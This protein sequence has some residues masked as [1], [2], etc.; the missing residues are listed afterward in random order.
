M[1]RPGRI[2]SRVLSLSKDGPQACIEGRPGAED[3]HAGCTIGVPRGLFD[4]TAG[5]FSGAT[6]PKDRFSTPPLDAS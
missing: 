3:S 6:R 1:T 2:L 5:I 4:C